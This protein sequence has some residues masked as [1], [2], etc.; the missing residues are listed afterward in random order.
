VEGTAK[1]PQIKN[2]SAARAISI[3]NVYNMELEN[4]A[5]GPGDF[6]YRSGS[7]KWDVESGMW[8]IFR[9][10][11]SSILCKCKSMICKFTE[12]KKK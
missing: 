9:V 10:K 2:N 7:L 6:L 4:G 3:G 1:G 12:G 5:S 8:G 11:K